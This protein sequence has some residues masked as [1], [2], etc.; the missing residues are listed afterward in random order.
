MSQNSC[1]FKKFPSNFFNSNLGS[2]AKLTLSF[3]FSL[4]PVSFRIEI[5][6]CISNHLLHSK[7]LHCWYCFPFS[8]SVF[9]PQ[10]AFMNV[11]AFFPPRFFLFQV[12]VFFFCLFP[13]ALVFVLDFFFIFLPF[14]ISN[15]FSLLISLISL[16]H[17]LLFVYTPLI[18][19][20]FFI[21]RQ[22]LFK[23]LQV[24]TEIIQWRATYMPFLQRRHS[25]CSP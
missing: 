21:F 2:L 13:L 18:G 14:K 4:L 8:L 12:C 20:F 5:F 17:H 15:P 22:C 1:H 7:F 23:F 19:F 6:S 9:S 25:I 3:Y 10:L 16:F 24:F 11:S